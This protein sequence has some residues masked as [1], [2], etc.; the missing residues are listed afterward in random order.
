MTG[1]YSQILRIGSD[2]HTRQ[3]GIQV[4][5]I[6]KLRVRSTLQFNPGERDLTVALASLHRVPRSSE[7]DQGLSHEAG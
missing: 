1:P 3:P 5:E 7:I 6:N 2:S 4:D